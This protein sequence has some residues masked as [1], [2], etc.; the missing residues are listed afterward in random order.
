MIDLKYTITKF[1]NENKIVTVAFEN[2]EWAELKLVNPLPKNIQELES[3]I[4][5]F[6]APIEAIEARTNPDADLSYIDSL[7]GTEI[8]TTRKQLTPVPSKPAV[9]PEIDPEV[10]ANLKMW[11]E[12]EFQQKLGDALVK[13]GVLESNPATIPVASI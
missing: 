8:T 11:E 4:K 7:L 13:L 5:N 2:G 1:D 3:I 6:A 12:I 10:E 9:E